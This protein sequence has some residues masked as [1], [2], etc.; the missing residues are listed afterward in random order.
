MATNEGHSRTLLAYV[1]HRYDWSETSLIV[2][3]FTRQQGRVVVAAKGAKRPTSHLRPV[4]LPFQPLLAHL[5]KRPADDQAEV[6]TLRTAEWV[7]GTPLLGAAAMF[8]G[9][10]LN[11]LLLKLLARQDPHPALFDAYADTLGAL[12]TA[13]DEAAALRAFEL[14][15]LRE[16]GVL[17][18]LA[19]ST[20]TAEPLQPA[21]GYTLDAEAGVQPDAHG[22]PGSAWVALEAALGHGS[23]AAVRLAATPHAAALRVPLRALLHYHLGHSQLR[24]RQVWQGVQR[25]A[26]TAPR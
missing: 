2:E 3:L 26:E 7:G 24:T 6:R 16:T 10:Y 23:A 8:P 25:L 12:A 22:P 13:G 17:P 1:L 19:Q 20:L 11:E 9:F 21:A 15:L 4:L 14:L 5:G 18:D